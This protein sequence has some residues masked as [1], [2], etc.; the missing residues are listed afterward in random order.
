MKSIVGTKYISKNGTEYQV[1]KS[2]NGVHTYMGRGKTLIEALMIRDWCIAN[3]WKCFPSKFHYL[4]KCK[5]GRW[6][7]QKY[8]N[9]KMEY[10]GTFETKQE[11]EAEIELLKECDWDLELLCEQGYETIEWLKNIKFT[12]T[13]FQKQNERNDYFLAKNSSLTNFSKGSGQTEL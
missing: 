10:F 7:I 9:G 3:K 2:I 6:G 11:A 13:T 12:K 4:Y 5:S 1:S 8:V